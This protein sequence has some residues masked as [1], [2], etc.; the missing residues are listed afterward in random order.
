MISTLILKSKKLWEEE[1]IGIL[2]QSNSDLSS[3]VQKSTIVQYIETRIREGQRIIPVYLYRQKKI[4]YFILNPSGKNKYKNQELFRRTGNELGVLLKNDRQECLQLTSLEADAEGMIEVAEGLLLGEYHFDKYQ[5]SKNTYSLKK[6]A[7]LHDKLNKK[8]IAEFHTKTEAVFLARNLVNEPLSYLTA[9]QLSK[10]I[11]HLSTLAGFKAKT[12]DKVWIENSGMG[13]LLAV[14]QGSPNPPTFNILEWNPENARNKKPVV[15]IGKGVVYDT[16]GLSLKSSESM[17]WMKSDMAG[18]AAVAG[19]FYSVAKNKLPLH[20]IGLIPA[21][22]N[23][24]SSNAMV[25]G[26]IIKMLG[27]KTVEVLNTDAEGRLI[28]ADALV[29]AK[30]YTPALVLDLATLT[31]SALRALGT[32]GMVMMGNA[33]EKTKNSLIESG[34]NVHERMVEFP[35]WEEYGEI[36]NSP[37]ADLKNIG[38]P[39]A[40]A[41]TAGKFLEAFTSYPWIHL[42]IAGVAFRKKADSYRSAQATGVGVRLIYDFLKKG[43]F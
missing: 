25:P 20:L 2:I 28:L 6:L 22:E 32:E 39:E 10:E 23:R 17:E 42:D 27:G 35:L 19:I 29:Y 33:P 1:A 12:F 24:P 16:G 38:G 4:I 43:V 31:G 15:L 18:A 13:G 26:D 40:G 8:T 9:E 3:I 36:L 30:K 21:T 41:I 5:T 37:I 7:L 34:Y 14:S 11:E